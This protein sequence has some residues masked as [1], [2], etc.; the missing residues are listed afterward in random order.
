[1]FNI[2]SF[3]SRYSSLWPTSQTYSAESVEQASKHVDT[4]SANFGGT[5]LRSAIQFAF[6]GRTSAK[7]SSKDAIPTSVFVLTDGEAW[8]LDGVLHEISDAVKT[9][10]DNKSL[11]RTFVLGVGND[12][13]T[14]MCEGI[15]RAGK[16]TAVYVAEREKPDSKLMGLLRAARGGVIED[17]AVEWGSGVNEKDSMETDDDFEVISKPSAPQTEAK[18]PPLNLF[19]DQSTSEAPKLG[20]TKAI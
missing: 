15:A 10:K 13:S 4:F 14:A 6:K 19:D 11:L 1:M 2:V 5:E 3:G 8:D 12:V 18:L 9:A 16:G 7:S 20:P 17:L